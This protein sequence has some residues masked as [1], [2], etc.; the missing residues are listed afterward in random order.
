MFPKMF[1]LVAE[2]SA[3]LFPECTVH[4]YRAVHETKPHFLKNRAIPP[5]FNLGT[6]EKAPEKGTSD[7]KPHGHMA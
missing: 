6:S 3:S 5:P 2:S 7:V 4:S 1:Q